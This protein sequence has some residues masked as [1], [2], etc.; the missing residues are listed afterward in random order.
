MAIINAGKAGG[1]RNL[2]F[3]KPDKSIWDSMWRWLN[4]DRITKNNIS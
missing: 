4:R 2:K 3:K 1:V